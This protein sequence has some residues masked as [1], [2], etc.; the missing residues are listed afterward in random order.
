M[1]GDCWMRKRRSGSVGTALKIATCWGLVEP[2]DSVYWDRNAKP[3]ENVD[4]LAREKGTTEFLHRQR[5]ARHA[6]SK[7]N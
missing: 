6:A 7:E 3:R 5:R 1:L 4:G 2:S